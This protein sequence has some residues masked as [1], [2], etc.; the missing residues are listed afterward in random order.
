[1]EQILEEG[2][3]MSRRGLKNF[4]R[5]E[6]FY[7][8]YPCWEL[9]ALDGTPV[10]AFSVF[11]QKNAGYKF[12][13]QKRY[14]EVVSRFID[15]LQ[16]AQVLDGNVKAGRLNQVI[17]AYPLLLRDGSENTALRIRKSNSDLWLADV[18]ER[19]D[20][21]PLSPN[22]FDNTLPGINRF[23]RLSE[24]LARESHEKALT[25]GIKSIDEY[26]PLINAVASTEQL[27]RF[28][29]AAMKQN[30]MFG[31][32]A[33]YT[34]EKIRRPQG[35]HAPSGSKGRSSKNLD[36]PRECFSSLIENASTWRDKCLWLM[37]GATGIRTSE[38]L[39]LVL[40]D[41]DFETQRVYVY[42]PNGRRALVGESHPQR[43]RFK[44]R[45]MAYTYLIPELRKD[46]FY[47]LSQYLS[48]EF[49]PCYA[50]GE[51]AYL[52]QYVEPKN[53]GKPFVDASATTL[54][55]TFKRAVAAANIPI[56]NEGTSWTPHSLRHMYGVYMVND[57]PLNPALNQFGL[58]L[59]D[60]Q[61]MMGHSSIKVTAH[62]ARTKRRRLE[63]KL[64]AADKAMLAMTEAE[65]QALPSFNIG[66]VGVSK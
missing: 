45:Q 5:Q 35:L 10:P 12:P 44:G 53:R 62:Y 23:L 56:P 29:I 19:L 31:N 26:T 57:F 6:T 1:M 17:D 41:I 36:F 8:G 38:A 24:S 18:A 21:S 22:S 25:L 61:M 37:L 60:V 13:T 49:V 42:D 14:A 54:T 27:S 32:V 2:R 3:S 40:D 30:T 52:F 43:T 47:A 51:P 33:K 55:K 15:Y 64:E 46:L 66:L 58:P 59:V 65:L 48:L 9:A 11:C 39:N 28:E 20:W 7:N 50:S 34:G 16:E 63:A 4:V